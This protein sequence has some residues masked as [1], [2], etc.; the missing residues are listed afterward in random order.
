M[1][2][3]TKKL[4]IQGVKNAIANK[5]DFGNTRWCEELEYKHPTSVAVC[6]LFKN[7]TNYNQIKDAGF[8]IQDK[9]IVKKQFAKVYAAIM[10]ADPSLE[11]GVKY[12]FTRHMNNYLAYNIIAKK[13][14][15]KSAQ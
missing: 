3:I 15:L 11:S 1:L 13:Q 4:Q 5:K 6:M 2:K 8:W 12:G 7:S 9:E 14:L 10:N